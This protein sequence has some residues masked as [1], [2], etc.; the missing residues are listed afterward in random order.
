[1]DR[2]SL[3]K[4]VTL[5]TG[6]VLSAPL[7]SSLLV[8]CKEL[9]SVDGADYKLQFFTDDEYLFVQNL[10]DNILP[11]TDSP[12]ATDVYVHRIID[13][14]V[15]LVYQ[16]KDQKKYRS[17]LTS[18]RGYLSEDSGNVLTEISVLSKSK[19]KAAASAK[20][21]LR[22]MRQQTIAYYLSTEEV[23]KKHLNYLPI[24][25]KYEPCISLEDVG[26]KAWAL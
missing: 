16:V 17:G 23:G 14:M 11:R 10:I 6:S 18:L 26:G 4:L 9:P 25:G 12:S 2:R 15:G 24:P 8:G 5:A 7:L 19:N 20:F 22:E 13:S 1:M 3:I 21:A